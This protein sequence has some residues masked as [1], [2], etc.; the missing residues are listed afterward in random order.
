MKNK[1]YSFKGLRH[2]EKSR[3]FVT[4]NKADLYDSK[5]HYQKSLSKDDSSL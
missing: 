4:N 5:H 1:N 2:R 3:N